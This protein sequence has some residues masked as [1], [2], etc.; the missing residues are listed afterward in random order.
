MTTLSSN[1]SLTPM[2]ERADFKPST[3]TQRKVRKHI[4]S[5]LSN[6]RNA[7]VQITDADGTYRVGQGEAS[8]SVFIHDPRTWSEVAMH[9]TVGAGAAYSYGWWSCSDLVSFMRMLLRNRTAL[10][11][12]EEGFVR[13]FM[14]LLR[15]A[16]WL[17]GNT[18]SGSRRNIAA[19]YDLG[20]N[21]FSE[22]LDPT[23]LYSSA[24]FTDDSMDLSAAQIAKC[25]KLCRALQL[26]FDD[27]L[28]EIGTGWGGMAIHVAR[29]YGCRVTTTTI[30][31]EQYRAACERVRALGLEGRVHVL[32]SD[33]RDLKGQFD[34]IVSIEMIEAVGHRFYDT[35][36]STLGRLLKDD[37]LLALQ[38]ITITEQQYPKALKAV[39]FIQR[40]IFP[41]S[42]IP[43]VGALV[44]SAGRSS[45]FNLVDLSDITPHYAET[46]RRWRE[47]FHAK[48]E[49][50]T[51]LGYDDHFMRMW[52]YYLAYCQGGF[53]ERAI[54]CT[55]LLFA[56]S[57]WRE[58]PLFSQEKGAES[59]AEF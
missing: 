55:H 35:Y 49:N 31:S 45:D 48:Q 11:Q 16:H 18:R 36:F 4:L 47:Q 25:D 43:S 19:H 3:W 5:V 28:L 46:L 24:Y 8:Y 58:K 15:F 22:W 52:D 50:I 32:L 13:L 54:A 39:D 53:H 44:T 37:G 38:A 7:R 27:H 10:D 2:T 59:R 17:K 21:F 6:L 12:L 51:H 9:G 42:C 57:G 56:R 23:M 20:N 26:R 29:T 41:G 30:S 33:Y 34:K 40:Y 1:S 14:P